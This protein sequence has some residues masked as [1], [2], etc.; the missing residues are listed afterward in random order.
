MLQGSLSVKE[1]RDVTVTTLRTPLQRSELP[2]KSLPS[3][4]AI[5]GVNSQAS[6]DQSVR[7][8]FSRVLSHTFLL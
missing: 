4:R 6:F 7:N 2:A 8:S 1:M 5:N 3:G